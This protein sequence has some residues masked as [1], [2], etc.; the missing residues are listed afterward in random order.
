MPLEVLNRNINRFV[1]FI[2]RA[3]FKRIFLFWISMVFFFGLVYF[4]IAFF[5]QYSI[6]DH[7]ESV[8]RSWKGLADTIYFSFITAT[9]TGYGDIIPAGFARIPAV[10][11]VILGYLVIGVL[12][13]KLVSAKQDVIL[14][15]L[16]HLSIDEKINRTRSALYLF[17]SD[18]TRL[19][20]QWVLG[21]F[22]QEDAKKLWALLG[23]LD[24][25]LAD[26]TSLV[27]RENR[28]LL[29]IDPLRL[30]LLLNSI[31]LSLNK[32]IALLIPLQTKGAPWRTEA[33]HARFSSIIRHLK[34]LTDYYATRS[35]TDKTKEKLIITEELMAKL[36]EFR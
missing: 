18:C 32:L 21:R 15:E 11:E 24:T 25:L 9:T 35:V 19:A 28:Y 4:S 14:E 10:I 26:S 13:F 31:D 16:Y 20:E 36:E 22:K 33:I 30:E 7:G 34:T 23:A 2:E 27:C 6:I 8:P 17:R 29:K 5:N 3:T 1:N 12:I